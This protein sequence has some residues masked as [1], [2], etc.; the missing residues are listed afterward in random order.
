VARP[1]HIQSTGSTR[2]GSGTTHTQAFASNVVAGRLIVA[3]PAIWNT[4]QPT[5]A[6]T[7]SQGNTYT[8]R[9]RRTTRNTGGEF[10]S[11]AYYTAI[12]GS[13]GALT[14]TATMSGSVFQ[15]L[16][17]A[18]VDIS[19]GTVEFRPFG[20]DQ[21][22]SSGTSHPTG[23]VGVPD[24]SL[25]FSL[26]RPVGNASTQTQPAGYTMIFTEPLFTNLPW[27]AAFA[28]LTGAGEIPTA[29]WTTANATQCVEAGL[30]LSYA[31]MTSPYA[32]PGTVEYLASPQYHAPAGAPGVSVTANASSWANSSYV[33]VL[34]SADAAL[35][36]TG[37]TAWS[38][39]GDG[40]VFEVDVAI[41][42]AASE[43][44]ITT[45]KGESRASGFQFHGGQ[46]MTLRYP[47]DAIP[48]GSRVS[49]RLRKSAATA[50]L[51]RIAVSYLKKPIVG[52][53]TTTT[54]PYKFTT[55]L[56]GYV[57]LVGSGSVWT[58]PANYTT[59]IAS[60]AADLVIPAII[61]RGDQTAREFEIDLAVGA[62]ASETVI[63]TL[64]FLQSIGEPSW[65]D[66]P[67]PIDGILS[68]QRVSAR[69]RATD[70][71]DQQVSIVYIEKPL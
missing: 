26:L 68:G 55:P 21:L 36:L 5:G 50:D 24:D 38:T 14:V 61:V 10:Q 20:I 28:E 70:G 44:V 53:L 45:F 19:G 40:I 2:S 34:A 3:M 7:D 69:H 32:T 17:I 66:L 8:L 42:A 1:T 43:T 57:T 59:L 52:R 35:L 56:G 62:A 49:V 23:L 27:S 58:N 22:S 46:P 51:W 65:R 47:L 30:A 33:E 60:A 67:N 71:G 41:G 39:A 37:I 18:E 11:V 54:K 9:T 12:A 15:G 25:V 48:N 29:N 16:A 64:R 13:S 63:S 6:I 31:L 4:P